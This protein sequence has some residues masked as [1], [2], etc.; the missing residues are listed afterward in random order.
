MSFLSA[1]AVQKNTLVLSDKYSDYIIMFAVFFNAFLAFLNNNVMNIS[2]VHVIL[3]EI[4]V[5]GASLSVIIPRYNILMRPWIYF[6]AFFMILFAIFSLGNMELNPKPLRDMLLISNFG[7]LGL[8]YRGN[9]LSL[10]TKM[11]YIIM[12]FVFIEG[13]LT[14]ELFLPLFNTGKYY[15][16]TRGIGDAESALGSQLEL[17]KN[18][19]RYPGRFS[20]GLFDTHRLSSLFLEQTTLANFCVFLT[21][22]TSSF[23]YIL[24]K[25]QRILFIVSIFL[26]LGFTDSRMGLGL[27][28]MMTI[29]H[30]IIPVLPT[31]TPV[32][33]MPVILILCGFIF[34]DPKIVEMVD[35][36]GGRIGWTMYV[37]MNMDILGI[38]GV[39]LH[40]APRLEDVGYGYLLYNQSIFG[41]IAFWLFTALIIPQNSDISKRY[42]H[43]LCLFIVFNLLIGPTMFS[44]KIAGFLWFFAGYIIQNSYQKNIKDI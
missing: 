37:I 1:P 24:S 29:L 15:F 38:L 9:P 17:F 6:S 31:K 39:G 22:I 5:M 16:N 8:C 12:I 25:H 2:T 36:L 18:A 11:T 13:F 42:T 41:M 43:G 3:C 4:L 28:I 7:M 44:I 27:V 19:I 33:Y 35:T 23:W 26:I 14:Q 21:I 10:L 20:L 30:F 32:F 34:Y 40:E